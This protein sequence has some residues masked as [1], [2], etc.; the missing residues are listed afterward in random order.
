MANAYSVG[1]G[2]GRAASFTENDADALS[3]PYDL[4]GPIT[5]D[6]LQQINEMFDL[7]FKGMVKRKSEIAVL[8]DAPAVVQT[9][10]IKEVS[11]TVAQLRTLNSSPVELLPAVNGYTYLLLDP[12]YA[13]RTSTVGFSA[14]ATTTV[15]YGGG[16]TIGNISSLV[17]A[18]AAELLIIA[19]TPH[20]T[21]TIN[22]ISDGSPVS[23]SVVLKGSTDVTG[24]DSTATLRIPYMLVE[25][26]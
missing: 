3:M 19:D 23:Q 11:L 17:S 24:G 8:E 21:T 25:N 5:S 20:H 10:L 7:L 4:S 22:Y 14:G 13:H 12:L 6:T 15:Q 16:G 18:T 2:G 26:F 1:G 9:L